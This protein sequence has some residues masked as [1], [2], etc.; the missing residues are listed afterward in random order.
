MNIIKVTYMFEDNSKVF[1]NYNNHSVKYD[2]DPSDLEVVSWINDGHT[3]DAY[4]FMESPEKT[5]LNQQHPDYNPI[6]E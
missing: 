4:P 5:L 3:I 6:L 1:I 2:V